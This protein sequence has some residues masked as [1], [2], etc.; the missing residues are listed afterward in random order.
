MTPTEAAIKAGIAGTAGTAGTLGGMAASVSWPTSNIGGYVV[1][2]RILGGGAA[3]SAKVA[4]LG[5]PAAVA[6]VASLG[7]GMG[8][9]GLVFLLFKL[10]ED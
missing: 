4:A 6:G 2:G 8:V 9:A 1:A 7:V 10:L 5:G 3:T